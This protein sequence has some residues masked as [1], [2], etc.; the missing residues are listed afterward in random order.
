MEEDQS[1]SIPC[2]A[3]RMT[4]AHAMRGSAWVQTATL[5]NEGKDDA[6]PIKAMKFSVSPVV[7]VAVEPKVREGPRPGTTWRCHP[8][9][10]SGL[11]VGV[12]H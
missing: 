11:A 5:T 2:W 4:C 9:S 3:R 12:H 7:R 1:C 10:F 6:H 8:V